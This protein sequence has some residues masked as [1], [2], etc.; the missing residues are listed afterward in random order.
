LT[1]VPRLVLPTSS[2]LHS[3]LSGERA[4]CREEGISAAHL[5]E[6]A[7]DF[8]AFVRHR[9]AVRRL[10]GVPVTELWFVEDEEYIGTVVVRH[11]L[12][13]ELAESGGHVGFHVVPKSRRR[14]HG[15]RMLAE[16]IGFCRHR[17]IADLLLTCD[18]GNT[19]SRRVIEANGGA[20][21]RVAAGEARYWIRLA[22]AS[23]SAGAT[24][25]FWDS[26]SSLVETRSDEG[27]NS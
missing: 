19:A 3:Y 24:D 20:L 7:A 1:A 15:T 26:T 8:D 21:E 27:A 10:W 2:V 23:T 6:A 18:E 9:R 13:P 12:T 4:L 16:A 11:Q 17:G 14:G 22:H 5:D 25:E